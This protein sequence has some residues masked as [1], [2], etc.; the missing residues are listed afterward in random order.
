MSEEQP[1]AEIEL[2]K[3]EEDATEEQTSQ[4]YQI[5]F[6]PSDFTL[7][8]Y[9]EK[10]QKKQILI[11]EFQREYIWDQVRASRLIE[12]FLM[13]LPVPGV[14]LYRKRPS[15]QL[16]VI[17]GQQRI[18]SFV[19]YMQEDFLGRPFRLKR[20][21]PEWDGKKFSELPEA[22][23]IQ[24]SDS[25]LRATVVQEV[26]AKDYES[27]FHIFERL[28]TGGVSL[29]SMEIRKALYAG[30]FFEMLIRLN[31]LP[32]WREI[33]GKAGPDRR[34]RDVEFILRIL[35]MRTAPA[36]YEKPM[37]SYLTA[38]LANVAQQEPA[39]V[40]ESVKAVE[41]AFR[42]VCESVHRQ[43]GSK[44][45]HVH[46]PLNL[47]VLDSVMAT[48]M[49]TYPGVPS[50]LKGRFDALLEDAGYRGS[51]TISTSDPGSV[52]TRFSSARAHLLS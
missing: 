3:T 10:W 20:V 48:L 46:G 2:E 40:R 7:G 27:I 18:L 52:G 13:G 49:N 24:L 15:N 5:S 25:I 50:D 23:Q 22:D 34:L 36:G 42:E 32:G 43:L 44:P 45:F 41:P 35:A 6:Y 21:L 33:V 14:F 39:E 11:P 12:S 47:A 16:L 28:N 37:K 1:E 17:D 9:F 4:R 19:K 38:Y 51:T 31:A 26:R 29:S 30:E 8:V